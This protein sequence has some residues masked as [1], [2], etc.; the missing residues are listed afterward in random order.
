MRGDDIGTLSVRDA[1]HNV[2]WARA[3]T[4]SHTDSWPDAAYTHVP[5]EAFNGT[6]ADCDRNFLQTHAAAAGLPTGTEPYTVLLQFSCTD[7]TAV[8]GAAKPKKK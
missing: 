8:A 5:Q 1:A 3:G 6:T 4:R 2:L 7:I